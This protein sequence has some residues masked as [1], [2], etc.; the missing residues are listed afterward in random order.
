MKLKQQVVSLELAQEMKELGA[1]QESLFKWFYIDS[2]SMEANSKVEIGYTGYDFPS[3]T[4]ETF[5]AYTVAELGE[6]LPKDTAYQ[7]TFTPKAG[8]LFNEL[9]PKVLP[10]I[11]DTEA[12]A[13]AKMWIYLKENGLIEQS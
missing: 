6:M 7:T 12:D 11:A 10:Q 3:E 13:R 9:P 1:P 8:V 4:S 5:S 2:P